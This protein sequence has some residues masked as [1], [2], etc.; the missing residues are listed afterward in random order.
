MHSQSFGNISLSWE[1]VVG[2]LSIILID[3]ILAGDNAVVIAMAVRSLAPKQRKRGITLGAAGAVILRVGLTFV[4]AQL[5]SISLVKFLGGVLIAWIAVKLFVEGAPEDKFR[6]QARTLGQAVVTV[7]IADLVMSVDN[8]LAVAGA[9]KGNIALLIF[10]LGLSIPFVVFTA[11]LLS[12][13][14]DKYP[15]I[16]Y[17]GALVLGRVAGEMIITDP[18][19]HNLVHPD[20]W[21]AYVVQASFAV[22]VIATGKLWLKWKI[23]KQTP[24]IET[25]IKPALTI[26]EGE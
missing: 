25:K 11:N 1:F 18:W 20:Q 16:V 5:L 9:S 12:M 6:R 19:I 3:L 10:G 24:A 8:I 21:T 17:L 26:A 13:L 7:M 23:V 14:M 22:G 4:A 2:F 15:V